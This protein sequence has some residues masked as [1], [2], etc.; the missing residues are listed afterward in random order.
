M[1][2]IK[3]LEN[4]SLQDQD[5][6]TEATIIE[7]PKFGRSLKNIERLPEGENAHLEATLSPVND[8]T[9]LIEW[10][11]DGKLL[12]MGHKYKTTCD[13][14]FVALDI[15]YAFPEDSGTYMCKAKNTAG[16]AVTTCVINVDG[17]Y[18]TKLNFL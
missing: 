2:K 10:Y 18:F 1:N 11:K 6:H 4:Y 16:E 9:M 12:P 14:G 15:L 5:S 7:K 13:F 17:M 8:A 3:L